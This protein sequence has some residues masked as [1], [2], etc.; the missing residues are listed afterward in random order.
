MRAQP[1]QGSIVDGRQMTS[2]PC[3]LFHTCHRSRKV[4]AIEKGLELGSSKVL[5]GAD[6]KKKLVFSRRKCLDHILEDLY[7]KRGGR[8]VHGRALHKGEEQ[9]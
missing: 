1:L 8:N 9:G 2:A 5:L 3:T 6:L 7:K 4:Q